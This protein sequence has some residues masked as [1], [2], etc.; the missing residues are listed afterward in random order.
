MWEESEVAVR[1]PQGLGVLGR[2]WGGGRG[3]LQNVSGGIRKNGTI[4]RFLHLPTQIN[5]N[6]SGSFGLSCN[7]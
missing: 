2:G 6:L 1:V 7:T 5:F 3:F 4:V